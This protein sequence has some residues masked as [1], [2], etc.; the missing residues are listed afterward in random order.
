MISE[1]TYLPPQFPLKIHRTQ[2]IV[3]HYSAF[4]ICI[5]FEARKLIYYVTRKKNLVIIEK[6]MVVWQ[7]VA[8]NSLM[9]HPGPPCPTLLR[10]AGRSPLK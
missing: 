9:F 5:Y 6:K 8:M 10:P 4:R 7:G 3:R 1:L 2:N